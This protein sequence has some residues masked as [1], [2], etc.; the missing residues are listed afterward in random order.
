MAK[1]FDALCVRKILFEE[2]DAGKISDEEDS[3]DFEIQELYEDEFDD[4]MNSKYIIFRQKDTGNES[5]Q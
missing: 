4:I 5:K 3:D 2:E 1:K